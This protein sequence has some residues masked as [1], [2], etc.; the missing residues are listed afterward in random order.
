MQ[1]TSLHIAK[2]KLKDLFVFVFEGSFKSVKA[3]VSYLTGRWCKL[4]NVAHK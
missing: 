3:V 2:T 1:A 4:F